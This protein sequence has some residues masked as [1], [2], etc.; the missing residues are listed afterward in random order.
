MF[1][2]TVLTMLPRINTILGSAKYKKTSL[3][4]VSTLTRILMGLRKMVT[5][6]SGTSCLNAIRY[7]H[8]NPAN[9][10][11]LMYLSLDRDEQDIHDAGIPKEIV[12]YHAETES[13]QIWNDSA[14]S[15][16][17]GILP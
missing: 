17:F 11:I 1:L 7:A 6:C 16:K 15:K 5:V 2:R 9:P 4:V 8:C 13:K 3:E 12:Q 14:Y 10:E